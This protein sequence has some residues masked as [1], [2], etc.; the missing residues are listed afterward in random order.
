ME[1]ISNN[2]YRQREGISSSDVKG[3]VDA[4]SPLH[5]KHKQENRKDSDDFRFGRCLHSM[6]LENIQVPVFQAPVNEKTGKEFG[7]TTKKYTEA[8]SAFISE[9]GEDYFTPGEWAKAEVMI[10]STK[11]I[12][13]NVLGGRGFNERS[14]F[15][16][17]P[18][19]GM[20]LKCRPD[21]IIGS[22][23]VDVKTCGDI[24]SFEKSIANYH[25]HIQAAFY[26]DVFELST[27]S[28]L[29][30]FLFVAVEKQAPFDCAII[31]LSQEYLEIGR[32]QYKRALREMKQCQE[33]GVFPGVMGDK[34]VLTMAAPYWLWK[35]EM[36]EV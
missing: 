10:E 20:K 19:T 24:G 27:G 35:Q 23:L 34:E 12:A 11:K 30:G 17:C 8:L 15:A 7:S 16:T 28:K 33:S 25:Y 2:E 6:L 21:R 31:Q 36:E 1:I 32:K 9:V 29:T 13:S 22:T 5:W 4:V 3:W 18:D 26:M 14:F